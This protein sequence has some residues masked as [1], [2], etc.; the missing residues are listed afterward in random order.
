MSFNEKFQAGES[1][2]DTSKEDP[3]GLLDNPEKLVADLI[4]DYSG[5]R[6]QASPAD[7]LALVKQLLQKGQPLD[8]KKGTT[9]MLIGILTALPRSSKARTALTNK[10]I[11][12]L[13]N[14]LQHPPLSYVGGDVKY[15]VANSDKPEHK[16]HCKVYDTIEFKVPGTNVTL[17][18]QVPQAPDGLHQY[19]MPDGSF[20]NILE[21]NLGRAGTPYAKSV[22]SEKRLHG[23]K[24]DPGLLFDL[25]MA[26]GEGDFKENP[27]GISSMLFYHAA[28]IIH[29]IFRTNRTDMNKSDTSS[30]LDLAPLYGSSLKDQLEIRTMKEGKL[31]PDTFHEKRLLGQPAG[32]NVMLVLYS[33]F[34][35]YVADILLKINENGRFSL[36]TPPNASEED[37]AKAIAKQDHDLFNVAR[38]ITGG[39]YINIC[40]H[41]YLRAI[42]NTHHS[43]SDWTLDPRVAI[44][45]QFDGDGVPRGV[46][47][48]VSVEFNLLYRFHSC[49]SQRDE[50]WIND[51][52][53]KLFPGRKAED[54]Q[55]VSWTELGQAL[56]TF[57][58]N[59]PK[60]PSVRT[61]DGLER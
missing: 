27:A 49:I 52:F 55:D 33:R 30:Y 10:L 24:P 58:A 20:N 31:K 18:E 13:W 41:D 53:L 9:E 21:P 51:F 46:G 48:Q 12:T 5:V 25:L 39:L 32:V 47:N 14:N 56:L 54:L 34:H 15:E 29:D 26:R 61:F 19:R 23:V 4:K 17:R 36:S 1:Y 42:T 43:A 22:R 6:S 57:E 16:D 7:L 40:L 3:S 35:N 44:D 37:K 38:L 8:D 28:I 59:T 11:D 2:K 60:D 45:K 50:R